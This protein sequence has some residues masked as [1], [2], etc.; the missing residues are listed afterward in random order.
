MT[1]VLWTIYAT[2]DQQVAEKW[3]SKC[4]AELG[5]NGSAILSGRS[6]CCP[7][8]CPKAKF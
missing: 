7:C 6:I 3:L 4:H 2:G 5:Q 1:V 8:R